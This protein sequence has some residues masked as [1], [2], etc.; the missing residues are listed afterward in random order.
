MEKT[1]EDKDVLYRLPPAI[2]APPSIQ[3]QQAKRDTS[4]RGTVQLLVIAGM[5]WHLHIR[6]HAQ[7]PSAAHL[8]WIH[9][10][11]TATARQLRKRHMCHLP[12]RIEVDLLVEGTP[13]TS[14]NLRKVVAT[15]RSRLRVAHTTPESAAVDEEGPPPRF[16]A[17]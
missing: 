6:C 16:Q 14:T 13:H 15:S 8:S 3:Q 11:M 2:V 10:P 5:T 17:K 4:A 7:H 1:T 12:S 9:L